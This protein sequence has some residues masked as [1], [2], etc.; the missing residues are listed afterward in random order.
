MMDEDS[1]IG[2]LWRKHARGDGI[3]DDL[4][5]ELENYENAILSGQSGERVHKDLSRVA[6][7]KTAAKFFHKAAAVRLEQNLFEY[8]QHCKGRITKRFMQLW[9]SHK[10]ILQRRRRLGQLPRREK[11][12][13][14]SFCAEC[15]GLDM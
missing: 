3:D 11:L 9:Y 8:D 2:P 1:P 4:D 15:T 5:F 14:M 7:M 10:S 13:R 6:T 12:R